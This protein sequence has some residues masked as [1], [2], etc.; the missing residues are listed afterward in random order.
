MVCKMWGR[1]AALQRS[2]CIAPAHMLSLSL[3]L[4]TLAA[5]AKA[6]VCRS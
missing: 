2:V 5:A 1:T 4:D 3:Q 6:K